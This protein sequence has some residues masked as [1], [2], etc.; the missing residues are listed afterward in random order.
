[1][2][3]D[4]LSTPPRALQ[5]EMM[6]LDREYYSR[7]SFGAFAIYTE[8]GQA[9]ARENYRLQKPVITALF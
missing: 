4:H 8:L 1:M 2:N 7:R 5:A 6:Y 3:M 9:E